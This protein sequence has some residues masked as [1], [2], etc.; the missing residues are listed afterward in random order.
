M[1]V[2]SS[3]A[4]G[5]ILMVVFALVVNR[6]ERIFDVVGHECEGLLRFHFVCVQY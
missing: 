1:L 3:F 5:A 4:V 2:P 6:V